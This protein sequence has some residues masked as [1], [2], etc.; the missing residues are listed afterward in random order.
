MPRPYTS[1]MIKR[2]QRIVK[3]R[4]RGWQHQRIAERENLSIQRVQQILYANKKPK[5]GRPRKAA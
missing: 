1:E 2:D 3:W 5:R 4:E